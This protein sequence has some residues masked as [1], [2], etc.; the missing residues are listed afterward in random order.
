LTIFWFKRLLLLAWGGGI[1][2]SP[3]G[4]CGKAGIAGKPANRFCDGQHRK[5]QG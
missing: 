4:A 2:R 5:I 3:G 1:T